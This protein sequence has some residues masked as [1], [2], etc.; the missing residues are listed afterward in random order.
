MPHIDFITHCAPLPLVPIC[1]V[2]FSK[3]L[4]LLAKRNITLETIYA[5][6]TTFLCKSIFS[7]LCF[8]QV[9]EVRDFF[10]PF[11]DAVFSLPVFI[12][13]LLVT[14]EICLLPNEQGSTKSYPIVL[15]CQT[16]CLGSFW[17]VM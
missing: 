8:K 2:R 15:T 13:S 9:R 4:I 16:L 10:V 6:S 14:V 5:N 11:L 7:D 3:Q 17:R 12:A 1:T